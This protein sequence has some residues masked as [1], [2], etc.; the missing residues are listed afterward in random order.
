MKN[1]IALIEYLKETE[2]LCPELLNIIFDITLMASDY[3]NVFEYL[4]S[5][6]LQELEYDYMDINDTINLVR[7]FLSSIDKSYK[8][9]FD[10]SLIDG[11]FD[12]FYKDNIEE[13]RLD[14]PVCQESGRPVI[15][16][17]LKYTVDDGAAIVHEFMH[18]MNSDTKNIG[19]RDIFSELISI[20]WELRY[21]QFLKDIGYS[22]KY[23]NQ[24]IYER[25]DNVFD[26]ANGVVLS[27]SALDIYHNTGNI[28]RKNIK[29]IDK[30]RKLYKQNYNTI[31]DFCSEESFEDSIYDF[32]YDMGYLI[33]GVIAV[34][35]LKKYKLND[36]RIKYIND[37]IDNL[38]IDDVFKI[39]D[40]DIKD[41]YK[42]IGYCKDVFESLEGVIYEDC[43][44]NSRTY[45]SR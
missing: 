4:L 15:N 6:D 39:L 9:K 12:I 27:G 20:Y 44:S 23:F 38:S 33:G 28:N 40:L 16:M 31:M 14:Y 1:E 2:K 45:R 22:D 41:S 17:P 18:Y 32:H 10:K 30:Y 37:N 34:N 25:L 42:W 43:N 36:I 3:L 13:D 26:S 8:D 5:D 29:F 11:T 24:G 19:T 21:Y 7:I 35:L